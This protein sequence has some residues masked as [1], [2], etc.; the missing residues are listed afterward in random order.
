MA[1]KDGILLEKIKKSVIHVANLL[2]WRW[3]VYQVSD[4]QTEFTGQG[5]KVLG[6]EHLQTVTSSRLPE[7]KFGRR[8]KHESP[9]C[10]VGGL[11]SAM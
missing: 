9:C 4:M 2:E 5:V 1:K 3:L 6:N 8:L 10:G 7:R 11:I